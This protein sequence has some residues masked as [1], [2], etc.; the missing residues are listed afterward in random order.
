MEQVQQLRNRMNANRTDRH[1]SV[2]QFEKFLTRTVVDENG[3]HKRTMGDPY[4]VRVTDLER[5]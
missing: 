1:A 3:N 2:K 4:P 5:F